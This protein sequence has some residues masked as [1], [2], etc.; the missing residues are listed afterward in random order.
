[1]TMKRDELIRHAESAADHARSP[2]SGV[3]VGAAAVSEDGRLWTGCN[4]ENASY[5]MTLCAERVALFKGLSEGAKRFDRIAIWSD[6]GFL[7]YPCGA[8]LQVLAEWMPQ[9][10]KVWIAGQGNK[11]EEHLVRELLPHSLQDLRD[12]LSHEET[13]D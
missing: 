2:Y 12:H 13:D 10:A 6:T 1:M 8:C 7:L 5:S 4:I 9:D 11:K 3:R